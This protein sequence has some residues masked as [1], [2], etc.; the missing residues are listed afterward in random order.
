MNT[1][2]LLI[3]KEKNLTAAPDK[4]VADIEKSEQEIYNKLVALLSRLKQSDGKIIISKENLAIGADI[5]NELKS[6]ILTKDFLTGLK[7]FA[8]NFDK[9]AQYTDDYYRKTFGSFKPVASADAVLQVAKNQALHKLIGLEMESNFIKP[10]SDMVI[11]AIS[12]GSTFENLLIDTRI[13][14]L[15]K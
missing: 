6:I 11:N 2:E 8:N 14:I 7:Q 5:D 9:Q 10:I 4:L 13:F 3:Q 15:G 12:S 1:D